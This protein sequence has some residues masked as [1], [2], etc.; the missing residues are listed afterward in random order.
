MFGDIFRHSTKPG[1]SSKP[2]VL[3]CLE[4]GTDKLEHWD[5]IVRTVG[6]Q[7]GLLRRPDGEFTRS[8]GGPSP[9]Y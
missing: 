7:T 5:K 3:L 8:P 1:S 4:F 9:G 2:V 6:H